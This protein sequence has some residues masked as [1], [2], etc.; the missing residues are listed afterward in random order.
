MI[1]KF[2]AKLQLL[3]STSIIKSPKMGLIDESR[4]ANSL[5]KIEG[6][7]EMN[8]HP[9]G[10]A[11]INVLKKLYLPGFHHAHKVYTHVSNYVIYKRCFSCQTILTLNRA[12]DAFVVAE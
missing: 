6:A 7:L 8:S 3:E 9:G 1:R 12:D 5:I 11:S 4:S 10:I 2:S